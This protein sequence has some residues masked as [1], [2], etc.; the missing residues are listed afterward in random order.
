MRR[1]AAVFTVAARVIGSLRPSMALIAERSLRYQR[2]AHSSPT[3]FPG[4]RGGT[5]CPPRQSRSTLLPAATCL[6][7]RYQT[8]RVGE[9]TKP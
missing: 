6:G 9:A 4:A 3:Y 8:L 5:W 7:Q 1:S 2:L